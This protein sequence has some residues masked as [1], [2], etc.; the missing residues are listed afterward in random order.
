MH[1]MSLMIETVRSEMIVRRKGLDDPKPPIMGIL[2]PRSAAGTPTFRKKLHSESHDMHA[3]MA[4]AI[5]NRCCL[6]SPHKTNYHLLTDWSNILR[7]PP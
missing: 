1:A 6:H 4:V 3:D 5:L 2:Y 7:R